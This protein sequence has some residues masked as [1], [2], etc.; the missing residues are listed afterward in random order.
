MGAP[1]VESRSNQLA[2]FS[3]ACK[4]CC[5]YGFYGILWVWV[6]FFKMWMLVHRE[7]SG[8]GSLGGDAEIYIGR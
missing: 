7:A 4:I 1:L 8:N 5:L 3:W 6:G 2:E